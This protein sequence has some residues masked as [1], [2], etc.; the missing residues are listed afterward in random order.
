MQTILERRFVML[1]VQ[2]AIMHLLANVHCCQL[3]WATANTDQ[4]DP[5][6]KRTLTY[7]VLLL[8]ESAAPV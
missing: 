5:A 4:N 7:D 1:C 3:H 6:D 8:F 2:E